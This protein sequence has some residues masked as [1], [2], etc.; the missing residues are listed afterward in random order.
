MK[1][2]NNSLCFSQNIKP[3]DVVFGTIM[4]KSTPG[5]IVKVACSTGSLNRFVQDLTIRVKNV[6]RKHV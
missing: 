4:S 2:F 6:N 1:F 5:Y 3:K